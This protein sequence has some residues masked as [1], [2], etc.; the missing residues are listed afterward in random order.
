LDTLP[1]M[2]DGLVGISPSCIK[3]GDDPWLIVTHYKS[4][5]TSTMTVPCSTAVSIY[6][7]ACNWCSETSKTMA[8]ISRV[9]V[10]KHVASLA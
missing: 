4:T 5:G 1:M 10:L 6:S 8:S 3:P 2:V 9:D 7:R